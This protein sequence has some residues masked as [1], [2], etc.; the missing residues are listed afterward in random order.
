[1]QKSNYH[2]DRPTICYA[3]KAL[4]AV[5]TDNLKI[6]KELLDDFLKKCEH[7]EIQEISEIQEIRDLLSAAEICIEQAKKK[8]GNLLEILE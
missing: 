4:S 1:M 6:S 3:D 8:L 7:K 2:Y 5:R